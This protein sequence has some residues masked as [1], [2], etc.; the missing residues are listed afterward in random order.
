M[1]IATVCFQQD[2]AFDFVNML[3]V[4]EYTARKHNKGAKIK[5]LRITPPEKKERES[6]ALMPYNPTYAFLEL[7]KWVLQQDEE[8]ILTDADIMFTGDCKEVFYLDFDIA[9]TV[10]PADCWLNAGVLFYKPTER[11]KKLLR[12]IIT[13]TEIIADAPLT[14]SDYLKKYL[15]A[16]QAAIAVIVEK[17]G[18]LQLPCEI[19]NSEQHSWSKF[20]EATKIVHLKSSLGQL[21]RGEPM[22]SEYE[23]GHKIY[24]LYNLFQYYL[25]RATK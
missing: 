17:E 4:W 14:Y 23:K 19:W 21:V 18:L 3:K 7:A 6:D 2:N 5:I 15:G 22:G 13:L 8:C 1:I 9:G 12:E 24:D 10:R 11:G 25:K 16:D 20:S